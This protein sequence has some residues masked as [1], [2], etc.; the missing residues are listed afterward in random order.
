MS[1]SGI[2]N[3]LFAAARYCAFHAFFLSRSIESIALH[4]QPNVRAEP[5]A[6]AGSLRPA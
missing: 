4:M 5:P 3:A 2:G 6:E 1:S